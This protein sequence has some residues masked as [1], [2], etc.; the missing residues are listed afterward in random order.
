MT[1]KSIPSKNEEARRKE[2]RK[3]RAEAE[4]SYEVVR[5]KLAHG[6]IE[7]VER[8]RKGASIRS[9]HERIIIHAKLMGIN[10]KSLGTSF[11][12]KY[13]FIPEEM[14]N[15]REQMRTY[16]S[17]RTDFKEVMGL[18]DERLKRLFPKISSYF[19]TRLQAITV[20]INMLSQEAQMEAY[21]LRM[22]P[23]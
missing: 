10:I 3:L 19:E 20:F 22:V 1:E 2:A 8:L 21:S 23:K 11:Q 17:I 4:R 18:S 12:K 14:E 9:L 15:V 16:E 7:E 5:A 6:A 13:P